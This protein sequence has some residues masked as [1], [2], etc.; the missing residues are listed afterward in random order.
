MHK[1]KHD[2]KKLILESLATNY[3]DSKQHMP[4]NTIFFKYKKTI[5]PRQL[6]N[7]LVGGSE[8]GYNL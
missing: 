1:L 5:M 6:C 4:S 2:I 8:E 7:I 3:C